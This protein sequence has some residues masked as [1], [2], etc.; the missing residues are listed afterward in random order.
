MRRLLTL[1]I[2]IAFVNGLL[3][4]SLVTVYPLPPLPNVTNGLTKTIKTETNKLLV[5]AGNRVMDVTINP[6]SALYISA[7]DSVPVGIARLFNT[8]Y[9]ATANA[10][11]RVESNN[12]L[13]PVPIPVIQNQ[14]F[15]IEHIDAGGDVLALATNQGVVLLNWLGQFSLINNTTENVGFNA[16]YLVGVDNDGN[17]VSMT[18]DQVYLRNPAQQW[19]RI[20]NSGFDV[21]TFINPNN[22]NRRAL[23]LSNNGLEL[24]ISIGFSTRY[25]FDNDTLMKPLLIDVNCQ[26]DV[27]ITSVMNNP[28]LYG[29]TE[30]DEVFSGGTFLGRMG[31]TKLNLDNNQ[32]INM[33]S[34]IIGDAPGSYRNYSYSEDDGTTWIADPAT[35]TLL[36]VAPFTQNDSQSMYSSL[37]D[38]LGGADLDVN[39]V[40][41]RVYNRG[42]MFWDL[43]QAP[44]YEVPVGSCKNTSF[45]ASLWLGG[46]DQGSNLRMAAMT[47]RQTGTDYQ[48]GPLDITT[49]SI[50]PQ[51]VA[52]FDRVWKIDRTMLFNFNQAVADGSV[53]NGT[54]AIPEAIL[55]WPGNGQGNEAAILAPFVDLNQ[56]GIYEPLQG[57]YPEIKGDQMIYFIF[58]DAKLHTETG[59]IPI[60]AEIHASIYAY[61][62]NDIDPSSDIEALNYTTFYHYKVINR[63]FTSLNDTYIGF[64]NDIDIGFYQDDYAGCIPEENYAFV[65]NGDN[66]DQ[67]ITG[68]GLNPPMQNVVVLRGPDADPNDGFDNNNNGSVDETNEQ[69]MLTNLM[70]YYNINGPSAINGNPTMAM[71]YYNY[72]RTRYRNG[73]PVLG[74]GYVND[75]LGS[76]T[77]FVTPGL[78]YSNA[79]CTETTVGGIADDQRI[80]VSSG[81][82]T[83]QPG[84]S[85]EAEYALVYSRDESAPNGLNTSVA[86]NTAY[87]NAI[88]QMYSTQQFPS[89]YAVSV[90]ENAPAPQ[91][92]LVAYPNPTTGNININLAGLNNIKQVSVVNMLGQVVAVPYSPNGGVYTLQTNH[93][94]AGVYVVVVKTAT[95]QHSVRFVRE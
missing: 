33:L 3:A 71:D 83:L 52:D 81:P 58:N 40:K 42:D 82:F 39:K 21:F 26:D 88:K 11:Y 55:T 5:L 46:V 68:Y 1:L 85:R 56:N 69:C 59:G 47:Y 54:Y 32:R 62:C 92:P 30:Q 16:A 73:A 77:N 7:A 70:R 17:I 84:G 35:L 23:R 6:Y 51:R 60:G 48:P 8:S 31:F 94:A 67:G 72:L 13:T 89:C 93:L 2:C 50:T 63:A 91:Q 57:D 36:Q 15:V 76:P 27:Y 66:D 61:T 37:L 19:Q 80:L 49:V 20:A 79:P 53:A 4:Q 43:N 74:C 95:T 24:A 45:G 38:S 65:Y 14:N 25:Y 87:V 64:W 10:L 75:T 28:V 12:S 34:S 9:M 90:A 29:F 18:N 44:R 86:K 41:A 22:I 78:P